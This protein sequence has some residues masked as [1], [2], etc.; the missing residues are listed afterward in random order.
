VTDIFENSW[1]FRPPTVTASTSGFSRAPLQTGHGRNDM[2]SSIRSRCGRAVGLAIA[3]LEARDDP[4]EREHVRA[5]APHP[6]PVR[7]V[8]ALAVGAV[9]EAV[10][11]S[12][13]RSCHGLSRS[14]SHLSATAWITDS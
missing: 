5:P 6:V 8:D 7:H 13:V 11:L 12:S 10:L 14:I 9:E 4:L 3:A 2:Y 1:M